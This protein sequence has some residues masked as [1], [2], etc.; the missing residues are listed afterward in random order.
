MEQDEQ[1]GKWN[2]IVLLFNTYVFCAEGAAVFF[3]VTFSVF[4]SVAF[5]VF[6]SAFASVGFSVRFSV[7]FSVV[8]ADSA[9]VSC[10]LR[11]A[12]ASR[13]LVFDSG[14]AS[15]VVSAAVVVVVGSSSESV[16]AA[17]PPISIKIRCCLI[18]R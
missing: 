3:S 6:F 9:V 1:L 16:Q 5:S 12:T 2:F 14:S 10:G 8:S 11:A 4:F 13:M 15:V 18:I 17:I 7:A